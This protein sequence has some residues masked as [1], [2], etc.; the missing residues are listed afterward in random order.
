M[1][2]SD[3]NQRRGRIAILQTVE[4]SAN[5]A[6]VDSSI[7]FWAEVLGVRDRGIFDAGHSLLLLMVELQSCVQIKEDLL[8]Q[9]GVQG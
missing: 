3:T 8:R 5:L 4:L 9:P 6:E 7:H 2:Y 1:R